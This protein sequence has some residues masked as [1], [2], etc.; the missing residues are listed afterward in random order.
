MMP[1]FSGYKASICFAVGLLLP[2]LHLLSSREHHDITKTI[3]SQ[4]RNAAGDLYYTSQE[5]T[6]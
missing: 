5:F 1:S 3:Y 6:A 2:R 4:L